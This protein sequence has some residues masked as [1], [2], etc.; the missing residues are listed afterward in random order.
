[1]SCFATQQ[2]LTIWDVV[3][4]AVNVAFAV[5]IYF[6]LYADEEATL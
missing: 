1:M 5:F 2:D 6:T 4:S 3:I